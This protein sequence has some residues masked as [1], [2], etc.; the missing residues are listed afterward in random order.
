MSDRL[1]ELR[2]QR[3]LQRDH[4]EWLDR[5]IA[6]LEADLWEDRS[7]P[8]LIGESPPPPPPQGSREA[9][10]ILAQYR[11]PAVAIERRTK[12]GCLIYFALAVAVLAVALG[13]LYVHLR[14]VR[15]P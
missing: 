2:R 7:I 5:E 9:E 4:L 14:S 12:L 11:S 1:E 10:D 8:P 13:A 3:A 15:T 6:A